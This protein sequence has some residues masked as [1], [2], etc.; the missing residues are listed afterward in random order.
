MKRVSIALLAILV[1]M[2]LGSCSEPFDIAD[3]GGRTLVYYSSMGDDYNGHDHGTFTFNEAGDGGDVEMLSFD[4]D[5]P[6]AEAEAAGLVAGKTWFQTGGSR[7]TFTY[8]AATG[9]ATMTMTHGYELKADATT[10]YEADFEWRT[11]LSIYQEDTSP[12]ITAVTMTMASTVA[13]NQDNVVQVYFADG[14]NYTSTMTQAMTMVSGD[15]SFSQVMRMSDTL[16]LG[17]TAVTKTAVMDITM[18]DV[19]DG[20]APTVEHMV[21]TE[22]YV[23]TVNGTYEIGGTGTEF[24]K[25][26]KVGKGV[27]FDLTRT[28]YSNIVD[29]TVDAAPEAPVVDPAT[30]IGENDPAGQ[31]YYV[32]ERN[33]YVSSMSVKRGK[34]YVVPTYLLTEATRNVR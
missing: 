8:D 22:R 9:L 21:E 5:Y 34:N 10:E 33:Q 32:I 13:I 12:D 16:S 15:D 2:I 26:W 23:Y 17:A 18:T 11:L 27:T 3:L 6:T 29:D 20:G 7:G 14:D 4:Y 1:A 24:A 25:I 28:E 30:G 31:D 19:V